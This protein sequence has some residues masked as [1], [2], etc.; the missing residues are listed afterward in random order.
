MDRFI[1]KQTNFDD[2][3]SNACAVY[4]VYGPIGCGKT[5][6]VSEHVKNFIEIEEDTLRSKDTTLEFLSRIKHH[7][8]HV[9]IDNFDNLVGMPG[10]PYFLKPVT[11]QCTFLICTKYVEG[12]IPIKLEGRDRRRD[13]YKD[14]DDP[15]TF[16]DPIE[17]IKTHMT[18]PGM[19]HSRLVDELYCEHGNLMGFVHENYYTSA[20]SDYADVMHSL[21]DASV[22][23]EKMYGG[24]WELMPYFINSACAIPCALIDGSATSTNQASLWT[25][26][27]NAC[28]RKKQF[29]ES[30]L[31]LDTVDFM[32]RTGNPL[33]FY[34]IDNKNG[35]RRR[36]AKHNS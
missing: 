3:F 21:S 32:S 7:K 23:D 24:A 22:F 8:K 35:K 9:V 2:E 12:T 26:H 27:M 17:I 33:K 29:K 18:T 31:D 25:R 16:N 28:M 5:T 6:W 36:R 4:C 11:R 13:L 34:N 14:Y 1:C 20:A 10:A 15:D 30:R 19:K